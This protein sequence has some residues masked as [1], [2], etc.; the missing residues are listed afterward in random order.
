[1]RN[2][3]LEIRNDLSTLLA[4][5]DSLIAQQPKDTF[6]NF[7]KT[8]KVQTIDG[9]RIFVPST[10]Q[11]DLANLLDTNKNVAVLGAR[12]CGLTT[13][14]AMYAL[15]TAVSK[16]K[17]HVLVLGPRLASTFDIRNRMNYTLENSD[18]ETHRTSYSKTD[19]KF[20][21]GSTITFSTPNSSF[22]RGKVFTHVLF[23]GAGFVSN[24]LVEECL[25]SLTAL[26][27]ETTQFVITTTGAPH[28][29]KNFFLHFWYDPTF[30][31]KILNWY[32]N[33]CQSVDRVHRMLELI[34]K[35]QFL[36]EYLELPEDK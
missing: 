15:Y 11:E 7:L 1:M 10:K 27:S 9:D 33:P 22:I 25:L 20:M 8:R 30:E 4:R 13:I 12:Q 31:K 19:M 24:G 2:E 17:Q 23:D 29:F 16:A 32:D 35:D 21:N 5:I 14:I 34:G 18:C 28:D 6:I 26:R 3:L 36:K